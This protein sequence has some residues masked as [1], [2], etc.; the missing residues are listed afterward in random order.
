MANSYTALAK[1]YEKIIYD[2]EYKKYLNFILS[3]VKENSP[4][5]KGLDLCCGTGIF[6]RLLKREGYQVT[7]V[8]LSE[9]MLSYAKL[10]SSN[11]KLNVN[12]LIGDIRRLKVFEKVGFI[13]IVN[14]GL[15]YVKTAELKQ[16]FKSTYS[17]LN[18][19]G[20]L[21]FD[22]SS[23]HKL[24]NVLGSNVFYD[25]SEDLTY[26]WLNNYNENDNS[27]N[28]TLS[29]FNKEGDKY[30]RYDEEQIEYAHEID[31]IVTAFTGVGFT[32]VGV[33]DEFGNDV[34]N[35]TNRIVFVLK[36]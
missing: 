5:I 16:V 6:T 17:A 32:K 1:F 20:I 33:F 3:L 36:K 4:S 22:V 10:Y 18:K 23:K 35:K 30:L 14:D 24:K 19:G 8:D 13:S 27:L 29:L 21:V 25:N 2:N 31:D 12:Y 28:I 7:G 34:N 11:E 26:L 15:N 9:D